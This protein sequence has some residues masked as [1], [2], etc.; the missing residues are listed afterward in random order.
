MDLIIGVGT[1]FSCLILLEAFL[2]AYTI[3]MVTK[4]LTT[5]VNS[6]LNDLIIKLI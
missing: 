2:N 5:S 3:L 6:L 1:S 4:L